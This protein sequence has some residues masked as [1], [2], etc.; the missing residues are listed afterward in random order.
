VAA[1]ELRGNWGLDL[2]AGFAGN[3]TLFG[4]A[5]DDQLSGGLGATS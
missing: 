4:E 5:D 1:N 3:D 2:L